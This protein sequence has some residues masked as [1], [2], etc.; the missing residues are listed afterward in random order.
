MVSEAMP[1]ALE[2]PVEKYVVP[3][4]VPAFE[5]VVVEIAPRKSLMED[6]RLTSAAE[7]NRQRPGVRERDAH[8]P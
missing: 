3:A 6:P 7:V 8:W 5:A 2:G 1:V 4:V